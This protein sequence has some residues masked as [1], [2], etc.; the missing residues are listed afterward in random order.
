MPKSFAFVLLLIF[1]IGACGTSENLEADHTVWKDRRVQSLQT[2]WVSLAGLHWVES[3]ASRIGSDPNS[4][5]VLP[6]D[7]PRLLGTL[8]RGAE[9]FEFVPA[10]SVEV[11]ADDVPFTGGAIRTDSDGTPT[12][13]RTGPWRFSVIERY[14]RHAL[15]LYDDRKMDT[16]SADDLDFYPLASEWQVESRF[17]PHPEPIVVL[18]PTYTGDI[19]ELVSPGMVHFEIGGTAYRLDVLEGGESTYFVMFNDDTNRAE[20]YEAGRYMYVDHEDR[21]R[22]IILDF[23]RA[24][25]PPCAF[26]PYATCPYPPPQ[27]RLDRSIEAGEKRLGPDWPATS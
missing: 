25:N 14:S 13:L 11:T 5:I 1:V 3:N 27:N 16:I 21:N 20:T 15:R 10:P 18:T 8:Y 17:E 6:P 7:A 4:D 12:T 9:G 22:R 2:N 26:T 23:N 24:Y 19:Q